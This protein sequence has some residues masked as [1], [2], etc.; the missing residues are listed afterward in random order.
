MSTYT[1][2]HKHIAVLE[3]T[4]HR[5][6]GTVSKIHKVI[7][8]DHAP[9]GTIVQGHVSH[10]LLNNWWQGRSIPASRDG[11][12]SALDVLGANG[13]GTLIE[14][15]FGLSLSDQYWVCPE[16]TSLR[17]EDVNFFQNTFSEDMG[18]ILFGKKA[19]RDQVNLMSPD[20]T[21]D[22]WLRK[23]WK[24]IDGVR[25][26]VKAGS[27]TVHQEA[28]NEVVATLLCQTMGINHIPYRLT[29]VEDM[30]CS[31]CDTFINEHT[32]LVTA[33]SVMQTMKK[34][35]HHSVY[36]H[37]MNCCHR[38]GVTDV[39]LAVDQMIVL[40]YLM[41]NEDRHQGNFGL[42]RNA[43]TL[44]WVGVAPIFDT[45][46]ALCFRFIN[47]RIKGEAIIPCKPF[48]TVHEKQ[49]ELV[50]DFSFVNVEAL[51]NLREPFMNIFH[52]SE[53]VEPVR[54]EAIYQAYLTRVDGL[55][56]YLRNVHIEE[57]DDSLQ[58]DVESNIAYEGDE[59][60]LE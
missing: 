4:L 38:L 44:E 12:K 17:W 57:L 42:I 55:E 35:N 50:S 56:Q 29:M 10:E 15:C 27:G 6:M 2:M 32:E 26:L 1:L 22:G 59:L 25:C 58:Y 33:W 9:V 53:F 52:G 36:Q 18:D 40:D 5:I 47:S 45:G 31:V 41:M 37:Y 23:K 21:S 60:E 34:A 48:R 49:L 7:R 8:I 46:S 20:N 30:P 24:I 3:F 28:Y 39:G 14:K 51:R 19:E 16:N 54:A 11:L 13:T 43:E